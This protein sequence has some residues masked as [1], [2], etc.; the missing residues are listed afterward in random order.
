M[1]ILTA[2]Q[3]RAISVT[4]HQKEQFQLDFSKRSFH[5]MTVIIIT[6]IQYFV[7]HLHP[8]TYKKS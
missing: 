4:A 1:N 5:D 7:S 3:K 2:S 6:V 8:F